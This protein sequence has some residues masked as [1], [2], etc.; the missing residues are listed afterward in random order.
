[1]TATIRLPDLIL[2]GTGHVGKRLPCAAPGCTVPV[3]VARPTGADPITFY[4]Q[5]A[6]SVCCEAHALKEV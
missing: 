2:R 6:A 3:F 5:A 4:A 1:M